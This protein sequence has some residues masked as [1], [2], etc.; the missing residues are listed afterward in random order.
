[1]G[2]NQTSADQQQFTIYPGAPGSK[3]IVHV[4]HAGI[5]VPFDVRESI[6]LTDVELAS[7]VSVMADTNTHMLALAAYRMSSFKPYLFLNNLSR[8]VVDPE[9]FL[10]ESETMNAVGM[11]AVYTRTHDGRALRDIGFNPQLL[12]DRYFRPYSEALS[13]LVAQVLSDEGRVTIID[14]HSYAANA[15]PYE[16]HQDDVR[17]K[18]CI[19]VDDFHTSSHLVDL[20]TKCLVHLDEVEINQPF[21]GT[22]VPLDFYGV[23][24]SVQSVML[25]LRKDAYCSDLPTDNRFKQTAIAIA[26]LVMQL[27]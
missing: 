8:L 15:L 27:I 12:V 16:I 18:L 9:R 20:V 24:A 21:K 25:E 26:E 17:P 6:V 4:P 22:Y 2:S 13:A 1:M 14:L 10:D 7:E 11:G 3:V 5:A 19:G 23:D